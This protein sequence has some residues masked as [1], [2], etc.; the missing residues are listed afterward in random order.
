MSSDG[1]GNRLAGPKYCYAARFDPSIAPTNADVDGLAVGVA[2]VVINVC[3]RVLITWSPEDIEVGV[4]ATLVQIHPIL[5]SALWSTN[6]QELS[7]FDAEFA[8]IVTSSPLTLYLV[9]A[10][11][12]SLFGT[13]TGLYKRINSYRFI[14]SAVGALVF[15]LW[16]ALSIVLILSDHAFKDSYL[17]KGSTFVDWILDI[18]RSLFGSV[19]PGIAN[20][21]SLASFGAPLALLL[22]RR[23]SQIMA[24]VRRFLAGKLKSWERI[25]VPW[26]FMKSAWCTLSSNHKWFIYI[27][28]TYLD[29]SWAIEVIVSSVSASSTTY[30]LSYGQVLSLFAAVP[31][32]VLT[33]KF[34]Y[35]S[36][37]D[38]VRFIRHFSRLLLI[39]MVYLMTGKELDPLAQDNQLPLTHPTTLLPVLFPTLRRGRSGG[40]RGAGPWAGPAMS[41]EVSHESPVEE[42]RQPDDFVAEP[43]ELPVHTGPRRERAKTTIESVKS[44][45][46]IHRLSPL[47]TESIIRVLREDLSPIHEQQGYTST[48]KRNPCADPEKIAST[49]PPLPTRSWTYG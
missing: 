28:F 17:C 44:I 39:E 27:L 43:M 37:W 29:V 33:V 19:A 47:V 8:L 12:F 6:H 42:S 9:L 16:V 21:P 10:S 34:I 30:L 35:S 46:T 5:W 3:L 41:R 7:L 20:T 4:R 14:T 40:N 15:P 31:P 24:E 13:K 2:S 22:F 11:C 49:S 23:R 25:C 18:P 38:L 26:V 36:R 45:C 1:Q 32:F 48:S